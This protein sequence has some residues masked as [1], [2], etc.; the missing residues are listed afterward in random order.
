MTECI[1]AWLSSPA[2]SS[3]AEKSS[4]FQCIFLEHG[5]WFSWTKLVIGWLT[6]HRAPK[7]SL[8]TNKLV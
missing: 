7:T 3:P 4:W 2:L 1:I 6:S 8:S 5:Y